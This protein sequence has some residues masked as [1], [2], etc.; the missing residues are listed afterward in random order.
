M[1]TLSSISASKELKLKHCFQYNRILFNTKFNNKV[2]YFPK[3][4]NISFFM[5]ALLSLN[6]YRLTLREIENFYESCLQS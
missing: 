5:N 3:R 2:K 6:L 1:Q 4:E